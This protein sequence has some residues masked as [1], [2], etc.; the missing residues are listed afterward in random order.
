M[1]DDAK[2]LEDGARLSCD[3]C[4][5]GAGAAG[6]SLALEFVHRHH[7]VLVLE[8][9]AL[10]ADES[11]QSLYQGEVSDAKLHSPPHTY[12]QRRF[13]GSTTVWGGRCVPFDPIDFEKRSYLPGSGWPITYEDVLSYYPRANELCEAGTFAYTAGTAFPEG[14]R[15]MIDGFESNKISTNTLE[16]FSCPTDFGRRYKHRLAASRRVRVL[17]NANCTELHTSSDGNRVD[18]L[19]V[20]TLTGKRITVEAGNVVLAVGGLEV[21]RLLLAS[22]QT[23]RA[24][25]GNATDHVGRYYMCH[26]AGTLGA[27]TINGPRSRV[28]HDYER[29]PEGVYCRRRLAI[30]E[31]A[32]RELGIGNFV[33]RLHHPRIP[34]PA[35]RTG[36]LSALYLGKR[37]VSYEYSKRL[38]GEE[39]G[40]WPDWLRHVR[41]VVADPFN[42]AGFVLHLARKRALAERKFP[43]IIVRPRNG[44]FSIDFHAEQVPNADSRVVLGERRDRLGTPQLYIDWRH[45][46]LDIHTVAASFQIMAAELAG[47]GCGRLDYDPETLEELVMRDGAFGGHHIGTTRMSASRSSGVVDADC[48]VHDVSNLFV[49]SSSVFPTS[50]QANPTLT[51]VALA[52]RLADHLR[53]LADRPATIRSPREEPSQRADAAMP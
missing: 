13:G 38:H 45:T 50:S 1:I 43:T 16:R 49:A 20:R 26:M 41:N 2:R 5:V 24:G 25:I 53:K 39:A 8:S 27:L 40:S 18:Q 48:R 52:L 15:P 34:N 12:R 44:R 22:R 21:P 10:T 33:A 3:I 31:A 35:H 30:T 11:T 32:Q 29:S 7:S 4:V 36:A 51:I 19:I 9:G 14:M 47:S 46:A 6:I 23:Q 42:T 37:F 28:Y 17:L